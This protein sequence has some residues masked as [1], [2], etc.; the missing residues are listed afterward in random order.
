M[1][2]EIHMASGR[3]FA[4]PMFDPIVAEHFNNASSYADTLLHQINVEQIY[5]PL[6]KGKSDL[7][8]LDI[9][10]NIG[11]VSLYAAD[12][13]S[14]IVAVEP[15][16]KT[17]AVLKA[18]TISQPKIELVQAALAPVDGEVT[19]Y[20]NDLNT[21]ASSTVNTYGTKTTVQGFRLS[22]LLKIYQL[23]RVDVVKVDAEGAEGG[24]LTRAELKEAQ[25]IVDCFMCEA[26]N[27]PYSTWEKK[28]GA[29][30]QRFCMLGY[31]DIEINGMAIIARKK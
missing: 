25:P 9:G 28:M 7:T 6:F 31:Y 30:V 17:F 20:Q 22:S 3:T 11:L 10:A 26:H 2:P 4:V 1:I 16:P 15:D 23:E 18:M 19:F 24:S 5:A 29:L 12:S 8:F 21:T 27:C 13:C 14:R